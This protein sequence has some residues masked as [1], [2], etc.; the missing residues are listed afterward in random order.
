MRVLSLVAAALIGITP[1]L[2]ATDPG[3]SD[4]ASLLATVKHWK[5]SFNKGDIKTAVATCAKPGSCP[6]PAPG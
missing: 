6:A 2:A 4:T 5:D 1:A 3:G